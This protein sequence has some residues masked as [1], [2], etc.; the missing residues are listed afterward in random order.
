MAKP[1]IG[2]V[3]GGSLTWLIVRVNVPPASRISVFVKKTLISVSVWM[4]GVR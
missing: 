3:L 4:I 2:A 1:L